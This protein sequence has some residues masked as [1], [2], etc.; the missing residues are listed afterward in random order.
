M[1]S[2]SSSSSASKVTICPSTHSLRLNVEQNFSRFFNFLRMS[3]YQYNTYASCSNTSYR[4]LLEY[5]DKANNC[6]ARR[7]QRTWYRLVVSPS[8]TFI[9][10]ANISS[11]GY[12]YLMADENL[13]IEWGVSNV[14]HPQKGDGEMLGLSSM[15]LNLLRRVF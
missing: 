1:K 10:P 2:S 5:H 8:Y 12:N 6:H 7:Y 11:R 13:R 3:T 4:Y 15:M 9:K 14:P